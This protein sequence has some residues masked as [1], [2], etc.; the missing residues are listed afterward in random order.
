MTRKERTRQ[1][2]ENRRNEII[3]AAEQL[4]F[5][6]G[7]EKAT[8]DDIVKKAEFSKSTLYA[9]FKSKEELF[10]L[11]HLRGLEKRQAI[12]KAME[13]EKVGHDKLRLFG[14]EYYKFYKEYPEYL[15]LQ[16]YWSAYGVNF[17]KIK[18]SIIN[19]FKLKNE[20]ALAKIKQAF[21]MELENSKH[22]S[23]ANI[24]RLV[25]HFLQTLRIV[26]NQSLFPVDPFHRYNDAD[27]YFQYLD[28]FML[29]IKAMK[30]NKYWQC[31]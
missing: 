17:K 2:R 31:H 22:P 1:E 3:N 29:S 26:L 15:R 18:R 11:V 30:S 19:E 24:D 12:I 6:K 8:M 14:E 21:Q 20:K 10:L 13:K 7:Y 25:S 5:S 4:F 9:Y 23:A 27:Y 16:L 28:L